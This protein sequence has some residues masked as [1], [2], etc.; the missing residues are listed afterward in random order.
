MHCRI[1]RVAQQDVR[2]TAGLGTDQLWAALRQRG[3]ATVTGRTASIVSLHRHLLAALLVRP[4]R[5][6]LLSA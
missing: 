4:G 2:S 6:F 1:R 5:E 3:A